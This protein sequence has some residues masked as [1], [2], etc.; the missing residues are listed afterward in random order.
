MLVRTPYAD[1][2]K[3]LHIRQIAEQNAAS[4]HTN[5]IHATRTTVQTL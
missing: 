5:M 1:R 2:Q 4:V 3:F